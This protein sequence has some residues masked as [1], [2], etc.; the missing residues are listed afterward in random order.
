M[1]GSIHSLGLNYKEMQ[2][3]L[4]QK[5]SSGNFGALSVVGMGHMEKLPVGWQS[6][7]FNLGIG[8]KCVHITEI[9]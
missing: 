3:L 7:I 9:N 4:L 8:Y 2:E 6:A 5:S 1:W